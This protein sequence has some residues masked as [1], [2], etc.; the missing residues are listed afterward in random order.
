MQRH[1]VDRVPL[2][3]DVPIDNDDGE[4]KERENQSVQWDDIS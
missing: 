3:V 4:E 1:L 2:E